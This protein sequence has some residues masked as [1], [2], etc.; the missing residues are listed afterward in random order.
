VL[1]DA[2]LIQTRPVRHSLTPLGRT[3]VGQ[4]P[5]GLTG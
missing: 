2:N 3:M 1:R 4:L 5:V